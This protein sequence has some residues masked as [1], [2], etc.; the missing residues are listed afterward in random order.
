VFSRKAGSLPDYG[1]SDALKH[2]NFTW[3]EQTLDR[4]LANP[5]AFVPGAKM[6]YHLDRAQD[7]ADVIAFLKERAR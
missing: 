4:W 3:D 2:A 7:R 5:Q 6:F 1:Y